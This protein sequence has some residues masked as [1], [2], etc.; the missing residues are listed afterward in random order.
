MSS[1][2]LVSR[3][4]VTSSACKKRVKKH[5]RFSKIIANKTFRPLP[6]KISLTILSLIPRRRLLQTLRKVRDSREISSV[7]QL[8]ESGTVWKHASPQVF[9]VDPLND[10]EREESS[11]DHLKIEKARYKLRIALDFRTEIVRNSAKF[12]YGQERQ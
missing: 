6:K 11:S 10:D 9:P 3:R 5:D 12:K 1:A 4:G 7:I 2:M 8:K